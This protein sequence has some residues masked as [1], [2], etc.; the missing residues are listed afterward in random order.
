MLMSGGKVKER[1]RVSPDTLEF[2]DIDESLWE[3][4]NTFLN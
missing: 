1:A 4:G 3:K 2:K